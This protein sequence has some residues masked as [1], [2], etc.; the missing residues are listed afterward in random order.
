[1]TVHQEG[2]A[3]SWDKVSSSLFK[4]WVDWM[5]LKTW[6]DSLNTL[7]SSAPAHCGSSWLNSF[8]QRRRVLSSAPEG[9]SESL[10]PSNKWLRT[11]SISEAI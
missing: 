8:H 9:D 2:K 6:R 10:P 3:G 5:K 4:G 7:D 11:P 1:M